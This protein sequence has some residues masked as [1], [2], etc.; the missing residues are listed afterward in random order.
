MPV[1]PSDDSRSDNSHSDDAQWERAHQAWRLVIHVTAGK[2]SDESKRLLVRTLRIKRFER[3]RFLDSLPGVVRR[4]ARV[5]LE[6]LEQSLTSAGIACGLEY[7]GPAR[8]GQHNTTKDAKA[9]NN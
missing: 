1:T 5:D 7:C 3:E 4:G 8:P 9:A 6:H 2:L